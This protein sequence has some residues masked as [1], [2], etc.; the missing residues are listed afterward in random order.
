MDGALSGYRVLDL[1]DE[2]GML[3]ARLLGD[4]GA[5]VIRVE[6]PQGTADRDSPAFF[7]LNAGKRSISLNLAEKAGQELFKRL[8]RTADVVV[9]SGPP[10]YLEG[11]GA[12]YPETGSQNES[13]IHW[14]MICDLHDGGEMRRKLF[15]KK[16][17]GDMNRRALGDLTVDFFQ[18]EAHGSGR[19]VGGELAQGG[20]GVYAGTELQLQLVQEPDEFRRRQ[21][22][23]RQLPVRRDLPDSPGPERLGAKVDP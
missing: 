8:V 15:F 4:M 21:D 22:Q 9:E 1:T 5:E 17:A 13:A 10:G 19:R 6:S 12:G 16:T 23:A 7:Y 20:V 18:H 2:K 14:D 11:L 3:C